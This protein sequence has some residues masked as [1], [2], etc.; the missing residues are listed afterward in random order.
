M[1]PTTTRAPSRA[2]TRASSAPCP[3]AAPEISATLPCS[4]PATRPSLALLLALPGAEALDRVELVRTCCRLDLG[5]RRPALDQ[6]EQGAVL[7]H[8]GRAAVGDLHEH[9]AADG[10]EPLGHVAQ[11]A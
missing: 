9:G 8:R 7:G 1:S 2:N 10:V 4:R 5:R 6:L 3:R 11:Q